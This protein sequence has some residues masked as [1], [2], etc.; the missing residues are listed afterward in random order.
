MRPKEIIIIMKGKIR[1]ST[2]KNIGVTL[3][4]YFGPVFLHPVRKLDLIIHIHKFVFE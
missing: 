4:S 1:N 3:T 2:I